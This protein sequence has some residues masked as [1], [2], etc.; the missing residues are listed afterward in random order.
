[1]PVPADARLLLHRLGRIPAYLVDEQEDIVAWNTSAAALIID[2]A[3]LPA[4]ERNTV[5]VAIRLGATICS[6]PAGA[7]GE[8]ARQAAADL[9]ATIARYPAH[10]ALGEL[11]NEFAAHSV[12][13][14][15][16]WRSHDVRPRLTLRKLLNHPE[17]GPLELDRQTLLLPGTDLRL[18][19]YTADPDSASATALAR[20]GRAS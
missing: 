15:A 1:M 19:I 6:A 17:L 3:Q 13:F 7:E 5:R 16:G 12:D 10:R 11:V 2:F 18:V 20:L 8:F 9:R 14:A 4:A